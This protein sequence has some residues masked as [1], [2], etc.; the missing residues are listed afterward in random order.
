MKKD[1]PIQVTSWT[2]GV[3]HA[4]RWPATKVATA[5]STTLRPLGASTPHSKTPN[6]TA[7]MSATIDHAIGARFA[8]WPTSL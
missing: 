8:G 7:L 2:T 3:S 5:G 4:G 1:D 6:A